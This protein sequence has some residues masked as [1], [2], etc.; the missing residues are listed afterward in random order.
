LS[1]IGPEIAGTRLRCA[2]LGLNT[3]KE[4]VKAVRR[5]FRDSDDV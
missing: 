2:T 1:M 4:A 5:D 3:V